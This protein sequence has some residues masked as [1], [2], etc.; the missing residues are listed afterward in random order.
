MTE[1][2]IAVSCAILISSACSLMEAVL[3]SVPTR[4]V[5]SLTEKGRR[6]A[7]IFKSL[8][9]TIERPIAAI[10]SLNTIANTAGAAFA[11]SAASSVFGHDCLPYFSLF[12]TLAILLFSEII[13]KTAGVVYGRQLLGVV[14]YTL[15]GLVW[16]MAP[17]IWL[18]NIITRAISRGK[19]KEVVTP[20]ELRIMASLSLR[21]GQIKPYQERA[22]ESILQLQH[23]TV[24]D[25]MTP[26][27]V[28]VTLSE[29]LTIKE[30]AKVQAIKE[31]SRIPIYDKDEEDVVG[32]VLTREIFMHLA[33][34]K[35]DMRLTEL[36]RPIHFVV[37][38]ASL[39]SV[40][41]EFLERRQHIFIVLDEYGGISG[42]VTLEDI[43]E[44]IIGREIVDEFDK[45]EDKRE[46]ARKRRKRVV[47]RY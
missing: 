40:L 28:M 43:L 46:L 30:A 47:P 10:L 39:D 22:I 23:K 12:F 15:R 36:M 41:M 3:Y 6:G 44:E 16:L 31:H 26:R 11:G 37:E 21:S 5:E 18:T 2:V 42:L 19:G 35:G 25:V 13:P 7:A 20:D 29:H 4:Y 32:F 27:T 8:R 34:G 24:K 38:S 1:L 17:A 45:V 9:E 33:E 14:A